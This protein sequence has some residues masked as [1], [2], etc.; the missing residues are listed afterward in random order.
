LKVA[1]TF[2]DHL[3]A[4]SAALARSAERDEQNIRFVRAF[5]RPAG[6]DVPAT[7]AFIDAVERIGSSVPR[8]AEV[9]GLSQQVLQPLVRAI[10]QS[11]EDGWLRPALRDSL[12]MTID[13]ARARKSAHKQA[14]ADE[15]ER[16]VAEKRAF[17]ATRRRERQRQ[18]WMGARRKQLARIKGRLKGLVSSSS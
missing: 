6:L 16:R 9:P 18:H 11:S 13:R 2:P 8:P 14:A 17:L 4:L 10:A 3:A 12:E 1:R 5:V 15:R 7:P